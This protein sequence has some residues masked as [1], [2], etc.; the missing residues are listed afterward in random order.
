MKRILVLLLLSSVCTQAQWKLISTGYNLSL[1]SVQFFDTLGGIITGDDGLLLRTTDGGQH[2]NANLNFYNSY[3]ALF[4]VSLYNSSSGWISGRYGTLLQ[5]TDKGL[6]WTPNYDFSSSVGAYWLSHIV[7]LNDTVGWMCGGQDALFRTKFGDGYWTREYVS[8]Q[9][10]A[11]GYLYTK[12]GTSGYLVGDSGVAV[13][14]T[15]HGYS[16]TTLNTGVGATLENVT[17]ANDLTGWIVGDSSTI[18]RTTDGGTDWSRYPIQSQFHFSWVTFVDDSVGWIVGSKG[19]IMK[20]TDAGATWNS[21]PSG[22][23]VTL[24]AIFFKDENHGYIVGDSGKVLLY[25]TTFTTYISPDRRGIQSVTFEVSQNYPNPFNPTTTIRFSIPHNEIVE[26]KIFDVLG[27]E[28]QTLT[29]Q[30]YRAGT[31]TIQFNASKL[32]SGTYLCRLTAGE[33]TA[34][35]KIVLIK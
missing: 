29:N 23:T 33:N 35:R 4:S 24:R 19:A 14:T 1:Y 16:W 9:P 8:R 27:K 2:W 20:T 21:V 11:L 18:L 12:D 31:H 25:D 32:A 13:K 30:E 22:T 26:L 7:F 6:S 5:T 17:F 15:D 3:P 28:V 34:T 10:Y